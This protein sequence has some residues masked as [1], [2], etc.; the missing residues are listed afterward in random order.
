M[1]NAIIWG[2][3]PEPRRPPKRP[4]ARP[5]THKHSHART[6][7]HT[8]TLTD[9]HRDTYA[10]KHAHTH[11]YASTHTHTH[12]H[13]HTTL[14]QH[15]FTHVPLLQEPKKFDAQSSWARWARTVSQTNWPSPCHSFVRVKCLHHSQHQAWAAWRPLLLRV[16][17]VLIQKQASL[18]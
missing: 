6:R 8:H 2:G 14:G 16:T 18:N 12:T 1:A 11:T 4:D 10:R 9:T 7:A 3:P 17:V 13:T 15:H 5:C